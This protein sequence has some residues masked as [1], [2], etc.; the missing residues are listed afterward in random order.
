MERS[1]KLKA[2]TAF[3]CAVIIFATGFN[4]NA[5]AGFKAFNQNDYDYVS[6]GKYG[7]LKSSGCGVVAFMNCV[8]YLTGK[9]LDPRFIANYSVNVG[10]RIYGSGTSVRILTQNFVRDYGKEY[11]LAS[12]GTYGTLS[13]AKSYVGNGKA[14]ICGITSGSSAGHFIVLAEYD[15]SSDCF[16][17]LDANPRGVRNTWP[18]GVGWLSASKLSSLS[19]WNFTHIERSAP[20]TTAPTTT[21]KPTTTVAPTTTDKFSADIAAGNVQPEIMLNDNYIVIKHNLYPVVIADLL[22]DETVSELTKDSIYTD[23]QHFNGSPA[24]IEDIAET[25]LKIIVSRNSSSSFYT[26]LMMGDVNKDGKIT[27]AD[28]RIILRNALGLENIEF[29]SSLAADVNS[30]EKIDSQDARTVLRVSLKLTLV[31]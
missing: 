27:T 10:A 1:K 29:Y 31:G 19:A 15:R 28:S 30:N 20:K 8:Y 13:E 12:P 26:L 23:I 18:D 22:K 25:G 17:I 24:D 9:K 21:K 2:I 7:T 6:Y 5:E 14:V 3:M 4:L 16:Y 11:N